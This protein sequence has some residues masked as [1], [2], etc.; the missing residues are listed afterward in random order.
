M[1]EP[2][3]FGECFT[4]DRS[5]RAS[6]SPLS[7]VQI[8]RR[9]LL[10]PGYRAVVYYR[11]AGC[12]RAARFPR[13]A[14]NLIAALILARL[15]RVPGVEISGDAEIGRGLHLP[16]PHDIVVGAGS[17]VGQRVTIYNG[18]TLGA[19]I[20]LANDLEKD[21]TARYPVIDDDVTIFTGAKI[22][23]PVRIGAKSVVGANAV[24]LDSFPE[25]SV[26]VGVPA[27]NIA[28]SEIG[29]CPES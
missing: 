16:H 13:R 25:N 18:V 8:A 21:R 14:T 22:L 15:S 1:G 19:R 29:T 5:A 24:V 4:A 17:R 6:A 28:K 12:C 9:L 3:R 2:V 7:F 26:L 27:R 11:V 20:L 10:N 23:G